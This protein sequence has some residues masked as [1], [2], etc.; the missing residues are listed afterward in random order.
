[1]NCK[2]LWIISGLLALG[3]AG[4]GGELTLEELIIHGNLASVSNVFAD[5][6]ATQATEDNYGRTPLHLAA[7]YNRLDI[8]R[9]LIAQQ[10]DVN[11]R[12]HLGL[13]PL[14]LAALKG[15]REM[16]A[17][18]LE[19][20]ANI[21]AAELQ[22]LTPLHLATTY[23]HD[24]VIALLLNAGADINARTYE[25]GMT[26]L[27][28][29]AFC[30]HTESIKPLLKHGADINARDSEGDTPLTWAE[31]YLHYDMARLIARRGGKR[32]IN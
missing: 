25:Q 27:H 10:A 11:A 13:T 17:L 22:G 7:T 8:A 5:G 3:G 20:Q 28:W 31:E 12:D 9:W 14:H 24:K 32:H 1:M 16:A 19:S 6:A 18:L 4:L 29:A 26:P 30:G 23:G 15:Y 21:N 2:S